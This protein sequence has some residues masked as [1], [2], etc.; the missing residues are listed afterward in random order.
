[1]YQ[2]LLLVR[3]NTDGTSANSLSLNFSMGDGNVDQL[4]EQARSVPALGQ[5]AVNG[6]ADTP[7]NSRDL[8]VTDPSGHRLVFTARAANPDPEQAARWKAMF[9]QAKK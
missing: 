1:K 3:A 5:S 8:N 4:G 7:W 6:P 9:D 2:D